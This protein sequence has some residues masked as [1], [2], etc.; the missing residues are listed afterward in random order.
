MSVVDND[1]NATT[2]SFNLE[3][4]ITSQADNNVV[5]DNVEI[6]VPLKYL[7]N[8][9]RTLGM[10]LINCEVNVGLQIVL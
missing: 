10:L 2:N 4:K 1:V 7:S 5:L 6:M 8:F 3:S 9:L